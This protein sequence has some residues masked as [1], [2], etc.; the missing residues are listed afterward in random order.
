MST[1][2]LLLAVLGGITILAYMV[3]INAHG[4]TRLSI[5]YLLATFML[6]GTVWA[7]VQY[8]NAGQDRLQMA[9]FQRL[10]MEKQQVEARAA[11]QEQTIQDSRR[12]LTYAGRLNA[13]INQATGLATTMINADLRDYSAELDVLVGRAQTAQ[14]KAEELSA[15]FEKLKADE[16]YF[17][18]GVQLTGEAFKDL[19]EAAK[20]YTQYFRA[21]DSAQ[22]DLRN[23]LMRQKSRDALEKLKRATSLIAAEG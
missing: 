10:Q 3:A 2:I 6:A 17:P 22:E 7:V 21:E 13:V 15:E 16:R 19:V 12:R 14:R 5:S 9:E 20:Y 23:R 1:D 4:P 11:S 18:Q 8:V